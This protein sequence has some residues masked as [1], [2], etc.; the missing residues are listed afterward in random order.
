MTRVSTW[1]V[2]RHGLWPSLSNPLTTDLHCCS[3][4]DST[5]TMTSHSQRQL[6]SGRVHRDSTLSSTVFNVSDSVS[7]PTTPGGTYRSSTG[8]DDAAQTALMALG[9]GQSS[10]VQR[11]VSARRPR[12]R[13]QPPVDVSSDIIE[14]DSFRYTSYSIDRLCDG[15]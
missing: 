6:I 12:P 11:S 10:H 4:G 14:M 1:Q 8:D 7:L 2:G 9:D 13:H 3:V 15:R 5:S